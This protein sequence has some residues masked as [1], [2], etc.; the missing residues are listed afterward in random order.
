MAYESD[1]VA[2]MQWILNKAAYNIR[3]LN[4]SVNSSVQSSYHASA[5]DAAAEILWFNGVVVVA[6]AGNA[7]YDYDELIKAAPANDPFVITVGALWEEGTADPSDDYVADFSSTGTTLD[8]FAK[9]DLVAPGDKIISTLA[10]NSDWSSTHPNNVVDAKYFRA[11]GTSM[12]APMVAGAAALL[13]QADPTLTPDQVKFRLLNTTY[14]VPDYRFGNKKTA[15]L[16][17]ALD[18]GAALTTSTTESANTG[19]QAN[20]LL[21]SGSEPLN[22]NS[23]N[24]NSVNWNSVNW[25]SVNWNSVNWNSVNWNSV[26]WGD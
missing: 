20:Q 11:S 25:N 26:Y 4:L 24:W 17:P 6:S 16:V 23:V 1:T 3:V 8:G 13:L 18:I 19:L 5:L 22:W 21:W 15:P 12:A 7:W 10:P 14:L 9:P 2:A